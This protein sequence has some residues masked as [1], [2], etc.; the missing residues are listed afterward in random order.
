[1]EYN[2]LIVL[3]AQ[4]SWVCPI[5]LLT[6]TVRSGLLVPFLC[7]N[8]QTCCDYPC[9]SVCNSIVSYIFTFI[10]KSSKIPQL[11][12][13]I[14][15]FCNQ[16]CAI[17][18]TYSYRPNGSARRKSGRS[19]AMRISSL[20]LAMRSERESEPVLIWPVPRPTARCAIE[21]SSVSPERCDI[22][23]R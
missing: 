9:K 17:D 10:L 11:R 16:F 7:T 14:F 5:L 22:T 23:V 18:A 1:M 6:R 13:G 2:N 12:W 3:S 19:S 8:T 4:K 20:Y 21:V 15:E